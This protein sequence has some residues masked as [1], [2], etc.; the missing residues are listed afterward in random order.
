MTTLYLASYRETHNHG[1][2]RKLAITDS[3]PN[4]FEVT[5]AFPPFIPSGAMIEEYK[6]KQWINQEEAV[7]AFVAGY[8]E[9][10][11]CF[12]IEA[13]HDA[14]KDGVTLQEILPFQDGDTLLF[15]ERKG[16]RSYRTILATFL[17][18]AGY[19]VILN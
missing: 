13:Q 8:T 7:K 12:F 15:W 4:E 17:I 2:G 18:N 14:E 19:N 1:P 5:A 9:Q 16:Y 10:L 3:K 6:S 11:T